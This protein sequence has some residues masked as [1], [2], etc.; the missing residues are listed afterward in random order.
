MV[1]GLLAALVGPLW[2]GA[3]EPVAAPAE[4]P[5]ALAVAP[6]DAELARAL[7]EEGQVCY[8]RGAYPCAIERWQQ[9][10]EHVIGRSE[11]A[12]IRTRLLFDL[13][14]AHVHQHAVDR[15]LTRLRRA[16]LLLAQYLRETA[17]DAESQQ[18]AAARRAEVAA[19]LRD[20]ELL[21]ERPPPPTG[22]AAM[23]PIHRQ[24][25]VQRQLAYGFAG[26][27]TAASLIVFP[28]LY[29]N[30]R[31]AAI[32]PGVVLAS[33]GLFAAGTV[34]LAREHVFRDR[35]LGRPP[36]VFSRRWTAGG[37]VLLGLGLAGVLALGV[38][39][40]ANDA[41]FFDA[42]S[43]GGSS[44]VGSLGLTFTAAM[45]VSGTGLLTYRGAYLAAQRKRG[46][47][48]LSLTP[49]LDRRAVGLGVAAVF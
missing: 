9:A 10:Y 22:A 6:D 49:W 39:A 46:G 18:L 17:E 35:W 40:A 30:T 33:D 43:W 15:D 48:S 31:Y 24:A 29:D 28:F 47:A 36:R 19:R 25:R 37:G 2:L 13:A 45:L 26:V 21:A 20:A 5:D 1:P 34:H 12:A 23:Q 41:E 11:L 27:F 8:L 32:A 38:S 16:D 7:Y 4:L 44:W 42:P 14:G 3:P